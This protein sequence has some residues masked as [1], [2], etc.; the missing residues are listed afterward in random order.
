[1]RKGFIKRSAEMD[2][3]DRKIVVQY[4]KGGYTY[5]EIGERYGLSYDMVRRIVLREAPEF[6]RQK[7]EST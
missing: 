4:R 1:M 2:E 5:G 6:A 3:R 7:R